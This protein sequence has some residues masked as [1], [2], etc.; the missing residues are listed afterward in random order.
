[1]IV[2]TLLENTSP[3]AELGCEHGLS[4][5]IETEGRR[6]LFDTGRTGLFA[7]NA[8][9]MGV[10]LAAVDLLAISHGHS[11]HGGG[12]R[13]FLSRNA[14]AKIYVSRRA[15]GDYRLRTAGGE[16]VYIGLDPE[17]RGHPRLVPTDEHTALGEGLELF[18][19]VRGERFNPSGNRVLLMKEG[20]HLGPDDFAHEQSLA[21]TEGGTSVLFAGCAHAGILNI[22]DRFHALKG[23]MPDHVFGGFHLTNPTDGTR[24]T[25]ETVDAIADA[26]LSTNAR[27]YTGHCTGFEVYER[28]KRRMG[29]RLHPIATGG[30][31]AL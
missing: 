24:E 20:D 13:T 14:R 25:D 22:L 12:I 3:S 9:R 15:F 21:V 7:E 17:L 19:G 27:F 4:L 28:M 16:S 23:F 11:D 5:H 10:D 1:M 18:S 6:I 2:R 8:G 31:V 26:L 30:V 29:D